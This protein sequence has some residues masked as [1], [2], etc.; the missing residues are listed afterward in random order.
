MRGL[1]LRRWTSP[2]TE[3]GADP[4]TALQSALRIVIAETDARPEVIELGCPLNNLTQEMSPR[5]RADGSVRADVD[6]RAAADLIV[7]AIEG[8]LGLAKSAKSVRM[9]RSNLEQL[10]DYLEGL[11]ARGQSSSP[12]SA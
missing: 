8:S 1:T 10:C 3:S 12:L 9:L 6:P 5:G 2:V 7:A 4:I 11:R